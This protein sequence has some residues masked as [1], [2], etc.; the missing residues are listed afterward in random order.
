MVIGGME[1]AAFVKNIGGGERLVA[2]SPP[3]ECVSIMSSILA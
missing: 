1:E 2:A 3:A